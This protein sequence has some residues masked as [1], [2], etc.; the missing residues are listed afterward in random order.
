MNPNMISQP[1][2][3]AIP[4]P[5]ESEANQNMFGEKEYFKDAGFVDK[6]SAFIFANKHAV[7]HGFFLSSRSGVKDS[8]NQQFFYFN[9]YKKL[10]N[11][12]TST[13]PDCLYEL[14][15]KRDIYEKDSLFKFQE[16]TG[17]HS[18]DLIVGKLTIEAKSYLSRHYRNPKY[19]QKE[20]REGVHPDK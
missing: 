13:K 6:D 8:G 20:L 18:H 5:P 9:C 16:A 11:G 15:F 14:S 17:S 19:T 10:G 7:S 2:E 3:N 1:K 4:V 12:S